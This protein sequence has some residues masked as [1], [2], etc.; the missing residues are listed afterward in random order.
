MIFESVHKTHKITLPV[1]LKL[2]GVRA[3]PFVLSRSV[4]CFYEFL[5][6]HTFSN[7][8]TH[9]THINEL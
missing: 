2:N 9:G 7:Q 8:F 3:A 1:Q 5:F 4:I 6:V